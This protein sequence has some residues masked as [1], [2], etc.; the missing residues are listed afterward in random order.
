MGSMRASDSENL[1][2]GHMNVLARKVDNSTFVWAIGL[3]S[4]FLFALGLWCFNSAA[5]VR[6]DVAAANAAVAAMQTRQSAMS[7]SSNTTAQILQ[8]Q[9]GRMQTDLEWIK[10]QMED[11][12]A[13]R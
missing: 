3:L 8:L 6:Q 7:D 1:E 13:K 10:R 2:E 9:L 5:A 4:S 12:K 11:L